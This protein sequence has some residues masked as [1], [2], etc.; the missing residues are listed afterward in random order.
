MRIAVLS[1]TH[2]RLWFIDDMIRKMGAVDG[3]IHL[4]DYVGD[5]EKIRKY[6]GKEV[7]SVRGNC[8]FSTTIPTER[9]VE[10]NNVKLFITHGHNYGVKHGYNRL[11]HKARELGVKWVL[12]GHT[13]VPEIY[14]Q[15]GVTLINPGSPVYPRGM[16]KYTI[17]ILEFGGTR[18]IPY[19]MET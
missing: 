7:I 19:I 13:H 14:Q 17:A 8:D 9:V 5:A 3:I 1:D 15:D 18:L 10:F 2:G 16:N 11:V 6:T 4:G 12:Y